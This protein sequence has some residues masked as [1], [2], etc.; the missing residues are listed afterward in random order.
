MNMVAINDNYYKASARQTD[1]RF[2]DNAVSKSL[3]HYDEEYAS[4]ESDPSDDE[5]S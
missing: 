1:G 2:G 3:S 5:L 4:S